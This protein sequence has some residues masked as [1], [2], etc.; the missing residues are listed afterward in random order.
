MIDNNNTVQRNAF[1]PAPPEI[2]HQKITGALVT[3]MLAVAARLDIA[4]LLKEGPLTAQEIAAKRPISPDALYRVLRVLAAE[5]IFEEDQDGRFHLTAISELLR[6]DA[7]G[8]L[9]M[10]AILSGSEWYWKAVGNTMY[11]VETGKPVFPHLFGTDTFDYFNKHEE[12]GKVFYGTMTQLTQ[13]LVPQLLERYDFAPF[14]QLVDV[15]AGHGSLVAAVLERYP[16]MRGTLFD[17]PVVMKQ[18]GEF[19]SNAG[20]ADRCELAGGDFFEDVPAGDIYM[21][22]FIIHDWN[23]EQCRTILS[24]CRKNIEDNG[25]L[26]IIE[27]VLKPRNQPCPGKLMDMNMLLM[28]GGRERTEEEFD[29][30]CRDSGFRLERITPLLGSMCVIE[31]SAL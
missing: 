26:L 7:P 1:S 19:L 8:S 27:N 15:G 4:E 2:L 28:E 30:L 11:S 5:G 14:K 23:D 31:A 3:Q 29:S 10:Y 17:L 6:E 13:E 25:K 20:V 9:K 12:H 22:K 16:G 18:A 24:N 21:L